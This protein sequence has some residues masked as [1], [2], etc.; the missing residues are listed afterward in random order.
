MKILQIA[1]GYGKIG[2]EESNPI[3]QVI[4]EISKKLVTLGH[5]VTILER[6]D[7][8]SQDKTAVFSDV[9]I[10]RIGKKRARVADL[11]NLSS[12]TVL[13]LL[14]LDG[15]TFSYSINNYLK[16]SGKSFDIIH[17]HLPLSGIPFFLF[18]SNKWRSRI[19]YTYHGS[20]MRLGLEKSSGLPPLFRFFHP[21]VFMIKHAARVAVLNLDLRIKIVNCYGL[22][23]S[24]IFAIHN[25]ISDN[26]FDLSSRDHVQQTNVDTLGKKVIL[27]VGILIHRKG[28]SYLI[29]AA[30]ILVH[31]YHLTDLMFIIAGSDEQDKAYVQMI[32]QLVAE[33]GLTNY[34]KFLGRVDN[35]ALND[36][37][38]RCDVFVLPSLDEGFGLVIAEALSFGKPVIGTNVGGIPIQIVDGW[39]GF[40]VEPANSSQLAEKLK[41][42][43]T[44]EAECLR[45][46][47]NGKTWAEQKFNWKTTAIEYEKLYCSINK[48]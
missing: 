9:D 43:L 38:A 20:T 39:N 31:F 28:V 45:M 24:K 25:A 36:L 4:F 14:L 42:L 18:S 33:C 10:I 44:N 16:M 26:F 3:E 2:P 23:S 17:F 13:P 48:L 19:V 41:N 8:V 40:L 27:F 34:V 32:K 6:K 5:E 21:D 30:E 37:Y 22:D 35:K 46:G 47:K 12:P 15:L 11:F 1:D 29:K 7:T